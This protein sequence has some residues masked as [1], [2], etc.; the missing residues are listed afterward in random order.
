MDR[1]IIEYP[2]AIPAELCHSLI[3]RFDFYSEHKESGVNVQDKL[4]SDGGL[5][6]PGVRPPKEASVIYLSSANIGDNDPVFCRDVLQLRECLDQTLHRYWTHMRELLGIHVSAIALRQ[7]DF[8]K[9]ER[10]RGYYDAHVDAFRQNTQWRVVSMVAYL[11]GVKT[12]GETEFTLLNRSVSPETGKILI[13]PAFYG[14]I[15]RSR[16]A[17]SEG[18]YIVATFCGWK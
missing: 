17:E 9:Y 6:R 14:C 18:K 10:G 13:F 2:A 11:N 7:L 15:H 3:E 1:L 5:R 8:I 16:L 4:E 12:G